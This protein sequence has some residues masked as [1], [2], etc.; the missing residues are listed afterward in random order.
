MADIAHINAFVSSGLMNNP[1]EHCDIVTTTTHKALRGPRAGLIFYRKRIN[2][3]SLENKI[4]S[5]VFPGLQGGPHQ[6]QIAAVAYQLREC[7]TDEFKQYAKQVLLNAKALAKCFIELGYD[8]VTGGTDNHLFLIRVGDGMKVQKILEECEIFVNKNTV[9]GDE[10][11][12]KPTGIR[13]GTCAI[14]TMGMKEQD[15]SVVATFIHLI[16]KGEKI[17]DRNSVIEYIKRWKIVQEKEISF[18]KDVT[19]C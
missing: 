13:I 18:N 11:A 19:G 6:N 3:L 15:M 9:P 4:N 1:F 17:V 8:I 10:S 2:S 12:M 7:M 14:T 5:A 16:I